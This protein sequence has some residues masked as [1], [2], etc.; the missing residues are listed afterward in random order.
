[1]P[2]WMSFAPFLLAVIAVCAS[3]VFFMP[4]P[5]YKTLSKPSWTPPDWLFGP[6]WTVLYM[7]I[8]A[9]GYLAWRA[10]GFGPALVFWSLNLVFNA[11]WSWLMFGR[12][13][14]GAALADAVAMLVTIIGFIA[15]AWPS[16]PMAAALFVPYLAW[17][18]FATALNWALLARNPRT[19]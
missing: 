4:G 6:A 5:W 9:A 16:S 1:M 2:D 19:A 13:Q 10:E 15:T 12:H 14:I 18:A 17:V 11:L 3:G 8:A 7:M